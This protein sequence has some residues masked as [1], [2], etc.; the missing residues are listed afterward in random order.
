MW[1]RV[2]P[3]DTGVRSEGIAAFVKD[4]EQKHLHIHSFKLLRHGKV[5]AEAFYDPYTAQDKHMLY[6][7]S[8]SFT[9]TAVGFAVQDGLMSVEDSV[10]DYFQ[11]YLT[12]EPCEN[13]KK[14]RVKHLLTMNTGHVT[15][16]FVFH[17][18]EGDEPWEKLFIQ[19]YVEKEPGTHFLYNTCATYMLAAIVQKVT[20]KKLLDYLYEK[21]LT[22]LGMSDDMWW[23]Q[24]R[25]G[26]A[27]GGFGLNVRLDD[28]MKLGQFYLQEGM[29]E[30]KQLL[31]KDWV[32]AARTPWS[33]NSASISD[34]MDWKSGYGYQFWK[35][36]PDDIYRGDGA[37]GQYCIIMPSRDMIFVA[38]SGLQ[39]MHRI[40]TS[41]WENVLPAV[42]DE[43]TLPSDASKEAALREALSGRRMTTALEEQGAELQPPVPTAEMAG[44]F[45]MQQNPF[46]VEEVSI[47]A[48]DDHIVLTAEGVA[49]SVPLTDTAWTPVRFANASEELRG[50][51]DWS[52]APRLF[53]NAAA[54][55]FVS[56]GKLYL[57]LCYTETPFE[58]EM[59]F[60]V[61]EHG[62]RMHIHRNVGFGDVEYEVLGVRV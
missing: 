48:G 33:D 8:K 11:E 40:M 15:E 2:R 31:S 5:I 39:Q 30:G 1:E 52:H 6:S 3:E 25:T 26:V 19:S 23:E 43:E 9:S 21:F 47:A 37:F 13:M 55:A 36:E 49:T 24:S 14:M 38:N 62:V 32:R 29:W 61:M 56:G 60:D 45:A 4:L 44:T 53:E 18:A 20:G 10:T 17:A 58:D 22:P 12:C 7:L 57:Y 50:E 59:I 41:L 54:K 28:L 46:G 27:T 35:C 34:T 51:K 16:P 42:T